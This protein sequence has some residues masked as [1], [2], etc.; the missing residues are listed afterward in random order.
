LPLISS[1]FIRALRFQIA[2][3]RKTRRDPKKISAGPMPVAAVVPFRYTCKRR[4][5]QISPFCASAF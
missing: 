5:F 4:F 1:R 3:R 2:R